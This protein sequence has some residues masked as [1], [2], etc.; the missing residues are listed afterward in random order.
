MA[1][2]LMQACFCAS[3]R[4]G[5]AYASTPIPSAYR[6]RIARVFAIWETIGQRIRAACTT[7]IK[8]LTPPTRQ[9]SVLSET[10][11]ARSLGATRV[12]AVGTAP[13]QLKSV[14]L[15]MRSR[16]PILTS[17]RHQCTRRVARIGAHF[18]C[19]DLPPTT[20]YRMHELGPNFTPFR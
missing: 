15:P 4:R 11:M 18:L 8:G 20:C 14:A 13:V 5:T 1:P 7:S 3:Q 6:S 9:H 10:T 16:T 2:P 19:N 12:A 17:R